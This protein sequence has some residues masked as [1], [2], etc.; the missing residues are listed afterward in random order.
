MALTIKDQNLNVVTDGG[1]EQT[2]TS[3]SG[4][5]QVSAYSFQLETDELLAAEQLTLRMYVDVKTVDL[6]TPEA[7]VV[8][9]FTKGTDPDVITTPPIPCQANGAL[10]V[11]IEPTGWAGSRTLYWVLY[12]LS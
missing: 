6:S 11:S 10:S 7:A 2:I 9:E 12:R 5:E 1:G 3:Q 4:V 8:I